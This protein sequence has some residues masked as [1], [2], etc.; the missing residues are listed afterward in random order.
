M[1]SCICLCQK[2][3][4][5]TFVRQS[6]SLNHVLQQKKSINLQT[7]GYC[8]GWYS[9]WM[10]VGK[11]RFNKWA[12]TVRIQCS[13]FAKCISSHTH[14]KYNTNNKIQQSRKCIFISITSYKI[15]ST[16]IYNDQK[17][18]YYPFSNCIYLSVG[19]GFVAL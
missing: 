18:Y 3:C 6:H 5:N 2:E 17:P 1:L 10:E 12:I 8:N 15:S 19:S 9:V 13:C 11:I 14:P 7:I 16:A 4:N